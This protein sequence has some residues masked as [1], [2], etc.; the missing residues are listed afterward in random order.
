M[1]YE[2]TV[3][4]IRYCKSN[5]LKPDQ[6]PHAQMEAIKKIATFKLSL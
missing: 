1:K 4:E 3:L 6:A 2:E 5:D